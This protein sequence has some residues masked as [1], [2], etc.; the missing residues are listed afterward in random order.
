MNDTPIR[1]A[2]SEART[3]GQSARFWLILFT[4]TALI[5]LTGPFGTY[6]SMSLPERVLYWTCA[7]LGGFWLGLLTSMTLSTWL[8]DL[9]LGPYLSIGLGGLGGGG[10]IAVLLGGLEVVFSG[11]PFLGAT[12]RMLPNACII[13]V[14]IAGLYE[15]I[16]TRQADPPPHPE[17]LGTGPD[18]R[19][20]LPAQIG[21]DLILL[22]AQD[23]YVRAQTTLGEALV[24][25][26]MTQAADAL[27]P[28]GMRVHKSWWVAFAQMDRVV[29]RDGAPK[30][31]LRSGEAIPVGR[32]YRRDVRTAM[33]AR[34][35]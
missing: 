5:A 26:S 16:A 34:S 27:G 32:S 2:L 12:W 1:F 6:L 9:G 15:V 14:M 33:R 29:Y 28:L 4:V 31:M 7:A 35:D 23:H 20:R 8:E 3:L 17:T 10:A 18:W 11:D 19:A 13:A 24:R 30:L 25:S 22:H 21:Q